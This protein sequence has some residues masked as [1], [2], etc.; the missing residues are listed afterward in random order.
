MS[1]I[2]GVKGMNDLLPEDLGVWQHVEDTV[3]AHFGRYGYREVRTPV[4][5]ETA[6]F[7][8]SIG[9]STD[10]VG[11]EMYT[12]TDR[13]GKKS[14][15]L[16]PEGTAGAV[17]AYI[18][19]AVHVKEPVAKWWYRGPMYRYERVQAGRYRQFHQIGAEAFGVAEP[20]M[21]AD[22]LVMLDRLFREAFGLTGVRLTLNS[23]GDADTRPA[24]V[25][26]LRG[27]LV[28]HVD[29]LCEDCRRRLETNPL[30]TLDCKVP[31]CQPV[32]DA[33]PMI[34]AFLSEDARA[35]FA[36]VRR[37]L[38]AMGVEYE[39]R[40]RLVRGLDYYNRTA[41]EFTAGSLG[42]QNAVCGGGRYDALVKTLGGPDV[43]AIGFAMGV[44]RLVQVLGEQAPR[45][46][47]GP[48]VWLVSAGDEAFTT[49]FR[50]MNEARAA[51]LS[52]DMDLRH[53]SVKSQMRRADKSGSRYV[54]VL[55]ESE[56]AAGEARL[57]DL[58]PGSTEE[59][60]VSLERFADDLKKH[61][62]REP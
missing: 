23:L 1:K 15:S 32:L 56:L 36:E 19:H 46:D 22:L 29:V 49:C 42:A 5:E 30:R 14:L 6:L 55:G 28:E 57:K 37:L 43:P 8:R 45:A 40:P 3:R 58:T 18:Q 62:G 44:E 48:D 17:R 39:V 61:L 9:E 41:F 21:D 11:K 33:A 31:T 24:Y 16:R 26:A 4:V 51:G 53:G 38:D 10:I 52:A 54:V 35:H 2:S 25:A 27:H 60:V 20:G 12:F 34:D 47:R 7:A 13:K 50:L 59:P